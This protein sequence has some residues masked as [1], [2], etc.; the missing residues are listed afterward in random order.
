MS[1]ENPSKGQ[2]FFKLRGGV[3]PEPVVLNRGIWVESSSEDRARTLRLKEKHFRH[4]RRL[5]AA[6]RLRSD[7]R[8]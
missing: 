4:A 5:Q 2:V 8:G 7:K 1:N 3:F 6:R